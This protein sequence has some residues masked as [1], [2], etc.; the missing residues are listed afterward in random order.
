[1][2]AKILY[3]HFLCACLSLIIAP[4]LPADSRVTFELDGLPMSNFTNRTN[5]IVTVWAETG[6]HD[7]EIS[8][9]NMGIEYNG[10]AFVAPELIQVNPFVL[11]DSYSVDLTLNPGWTPPWFRLNVLKF[12]GPRARVEAH[13]RVWLARIRLRMIATTPSDM[14]TMMMENDDLRIK[15]GD[16]ISQI[17]HGD[18]MLNYGA[19]DELGWNVPPAGSSQ[20][21][22]HCNNAFFRFENCELFDEWFTGDP[23]NNDAVRWFPESG[24]GGFALAKYQYDLLSDHTPAGD[25]QTFE[26][27][28]GEIILMESCSV[29]DDVEIREDVKALDAPAQAALRIM[30]TP[31]TSGEDFVIHYS[32][33]H[34][35]LLRLGVHD[36]FGRTKAVLLDGY[37]S[38]GDYILHV[39][40]FNAAPGLVLFRL[41]LPG[42][43]LT[44]KVMVGR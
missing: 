20:L 39:D 35:G 17:F 38:A 11:D 27:V 6:D 21:I 23:L 22:A 2:P 15:E 26:F 30:P 19:N 36:L 41:E 13:S 14:Q 40:D 31:L 28:S 33:P 7:W 18:V 16:I 43:L 32:V 42:M 25:K 9:F 1:M 34:D 12:I 8:A 24:T 3:M 10:D 44:E 37:R 5:Y 4:K 29:I